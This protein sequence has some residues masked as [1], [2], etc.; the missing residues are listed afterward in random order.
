LIGQPVFLGLAAGAFVLG[1]F[2]A[3]FATIFLIPFGAPAATTFGM[4]WFTSSGLMIWRLVTWASR[5]VDGALELGKRV[6][7]DLIQEMKETD[8]V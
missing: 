8:N 3:L 1:F 7:V 6:A 2:I 5:I 4:A